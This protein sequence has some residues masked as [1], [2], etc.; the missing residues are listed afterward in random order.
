MKYPIVV[1]EMGDDYMEAVATLAPVVTLE[2]A[3]EA[4]RQAGYTVIDYGEGGACETTDT[5]N[6]KV[7]TVLPRGKM[8]PKSYSPLLDGQIHDARLTTESSASSYGQPVLILD[9]GTVLGVA[10]VA[11]ADYRILEATQDELTAL[12]KAGYLFGGSK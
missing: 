12:Q 10:D 2:E 4:A 8:R 7:I 1:V 11:L 3:K 9:D 5:W 6:H